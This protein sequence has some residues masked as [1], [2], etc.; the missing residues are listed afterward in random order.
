MRQIIMWNQ[1]SADGFY[2]APDGGLDWVVQDPEVHAAGIAGMATTG[3]LLFGR[4]TY[5]HMAAFWPKVLDNPG[6]ADPHSGGPNPALLTFAKFLTETPKLVFSR[7]LD[8]PSWANTRVV[9]AIDPRELAALKR[10]GNGAMLVMGSA[11]IIQQLTEHG[12]VDEYQFSVSPVLLGAGRTLLR[13]L[14]KRTP[15]RLLEARPFPSGTLL[16]RYAPR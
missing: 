2:A 11:S 12:L 16:L 3:M 8:K 4:D 15:L 13:D 5:E 6:M 14:H 1:V 10:D 9:R 7:T